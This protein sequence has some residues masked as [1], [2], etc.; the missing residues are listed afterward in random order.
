MKRIYDVVDE[1][2]ALWKSKLVDDV[3][4]TSATDLK[5]Y[6]LLV[7]LC[8]TKS[9]TYRDLHIDKGMKKKTGLKKIF[10]LCTRYDKLYPYDTFIQK[11]QLDDICK[12]H[13]YSFGAISLYKG[14]I[15]DSLITHLLKKKN[16]LDDDDAI[17]YIEDSTNNKAGF[18]SMAEIIEQGYEDTKRFYREKAEIKILAPLSLMEIK[19]WAAH[20]EPKLTGCSAFVHV[21]WGYLQIAAF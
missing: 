19:N 7:K 20:P 2:S 12:E 15:K 4:D 8:A 6:D 14:E 11:S 3:M 18:F 9:K 10:D 21:V 5:S 1:V 16:A 17:F 13:N